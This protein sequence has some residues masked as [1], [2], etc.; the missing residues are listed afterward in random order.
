MLF[1]INIQED[2]PRDLLVSIKEAWALTTS[3]MAISSQGVKQREIHVFLENMF[4][5]NVTP[6]SP[7]IFFLFKNDVQR[8]E[9]L[10]NIQKN[11]S[12]GTSRDNLL[13][14]LALARFRNEMLFPI[15]QKVF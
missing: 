5:I 8:E 10:Y 9:Y 15:Y 1:R 2:D 4:Q 12:Q 13:V 6:V 7:G 11:L 3:I 14:Y